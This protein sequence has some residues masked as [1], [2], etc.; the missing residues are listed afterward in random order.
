M[1]ASFI[2]RLG[3]LS[4]MLSFTLYNFIAKLF[5]F[6]S[7]S[8]VPSACVVWWWWGVQVSR[9]YLSERTIRLD[10]YYVLNWPNA[11]LATEHCCFHCKHVLTQ[12][13]SFV[14]NK[15]STAI[16]CLIF[17]HHAGNSN[18]CAHGSTVISHTL[19]ITIVLVRYYFVSFLDG[20]I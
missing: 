4:S 11:L 19:S 3:M 7:L 14:H 8:L 18:G 2:H 13:F 1:L 9:Y 17:N 15:F 5:I 12:F 6:H 10:E 20:W 16:K